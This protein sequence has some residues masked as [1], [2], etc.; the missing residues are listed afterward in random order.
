MCSFDIQLERQL[1]GE[2]K[3]QLDQV[4]KQ[5]F[6]SSHILHPHVSLLGLGVLVGFL[7]AI[8]KIICIRDSIAGMY[9]VFTPSSNAI[10]HSGSTKFHF[11]VMLVIIAPRTTN[12][13]VV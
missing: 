1:C 8:H 3:D 12:T 10:Y 5:Y 11:L 9:C 4:S 6:R 2:A 7:V 13:I